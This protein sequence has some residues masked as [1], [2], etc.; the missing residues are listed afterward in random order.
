M[1]NQAKLDAC[2]LICYTYDSSDPESFLHIVDIR[3]RYPALN[4]LPSVFTA[5][6]AD[7]DRAVQR[8]EVQPDAYCENLKMAKP[9]HVSVNWSSISEFFVHLAE[10]ATFPAQAFPKTEQQADRTPVYIALG[11]TVCA[12]VAF[13]YVWKRHM[14]ASA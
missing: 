13:A 2:D 12:G 1:E 8:T 3:Q 7:R 9:L 6:K 10:C 5:L 11:A 14:G 4:S